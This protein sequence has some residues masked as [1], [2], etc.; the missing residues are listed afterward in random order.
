M[1]IVFCPECG[2]RHFV[3]NIQGQKL[4]F[5]CGRAIVFATDVI[6][7][8]PGPIIWPRGEKYY[9][10]FLGQCLDKMAQG[11]VITSAD[12]D[13]FEMTKCWSI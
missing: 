6:W 5:H 10:K 1:K 9:L 13:K 3:N 7:V 8:S 4:C 2:F 11:A 12:L